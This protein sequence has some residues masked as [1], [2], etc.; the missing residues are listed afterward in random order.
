[1]PFAGGFLFFLFCSSVFTLEPKCDSMAEGGR[2]LDMPSNWILS[3][4]WTAVLV[5]PPDS[6]LTL[7]Q[8]TISAAPASCIVSADNAFS[9]LNKKKMASYL[10]EWLCNRRSAG[11]TPK[12]FLEVLTVDT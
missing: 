12:S 1:M 4:Q 11:H 8:R 10:Q 6:A 5:S 3:T 7:G 2:C 9:V